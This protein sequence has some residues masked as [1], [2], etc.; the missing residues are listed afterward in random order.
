MS[1]MGTL[2][3]ADP[4]LDSRSSPRLRSSL[5]SEACLETSLLLSG[6]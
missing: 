1:L 4:N 2:V 6:R 5:V 3:L